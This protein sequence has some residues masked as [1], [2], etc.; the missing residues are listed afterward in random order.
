MSSQ[1]DRA[2]RYTVRFDDGVT[3]R[4][5]RQTVQDFSVYPGRELSDEEYTQLSDA[6][7]AMS[8]KMRA[9][10][11]VAASNVSKRDLEQRLI[12]KGEDPEKAKDAVQWMSDMNLV[13]DRK[14]A[15]MIVQRCIQKGYG[16]SR[17]KQ[18]LY[19]KQ[20]PQACWE[21]ALENYPEQTEAIVA[22]LRDRL[23]EN[24][25]DRQL[26]RVMEALIRRG[27]SYGEIRKGLEMM[28]L[29][30]EEFPEE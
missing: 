1:P 22:F 21:D 10:R 14:T 24:W 2:G 20:I 29:D 17:A 19:Q 16:R 5:Y 23:G 13:D 18:M 27:H 12:H 11:I 30:T 9:V 7:A 4:L 26:H 6:A 28:E 3:M 25:D 8:A 15:E